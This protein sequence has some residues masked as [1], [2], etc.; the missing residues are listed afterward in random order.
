MNSEVE[1]QKY[2]A[3]ERLKSLRAKAARIQTEIIGTKREIES[4]KLKLVDQAAI[5]KQAGKA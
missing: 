1:R 4:C 3:E 2:T 5:A